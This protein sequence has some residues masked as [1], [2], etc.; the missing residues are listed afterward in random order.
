MTLNTVFVS[1]NGTIGNL[2]Y[3][4]NERIVLGKSACYFNMFDG[5]D[6]FYIGIIIKSPYFFDYVRKVASRTTI[7][8]VSLKSMR[9]LVIPFPPLTEQKRIVARVEELFGMCDVIEAGLKAGCEKH[10][11]LV[12]AVLKGNG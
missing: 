7:A 12:E 10:A 4:E 6:K 2:A 5:V 11:R 3:Y 8:N 1:I 9:N